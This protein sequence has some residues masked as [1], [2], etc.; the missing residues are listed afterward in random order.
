[1]STSKAGVPRDSQNNAVSQRTMGSRISESRSSQDDLAPVFHEAY[2]EAQV[3]DARRLVAAAQQKWFVTKIHLDRMSKIYPRSL[4][5][6]LE[7]EGL[8]L[9]HNAQGRMLK[10]AYDHAVDDHRQE[11]EKLFKDSNGA[12]ASFPASEILP[13][14]WKGIPLFDVR[15]PAQDGQEKRVDFLVLQVNKIGEPVPVQIGNFRF[16]LKRMDNPVPA[17]CEALL[18]AAKTV[19]QEYGECPRVASIMYITPWG[20]NKIDFAV[21]ALPQSVSGKLLKDNALSPVGTLEEGQT[22][23]GEALP[24]TIPEPVEHEKIPAI[25][26]GEV[27]AA[28]AS[29]PAPIGDTPTTGTRDEISTTLLKGDAP[30]EDPE[31]PEDE[32]IGVVVQTMAKPLQQGRG[33]VPKNSIRIEGWIY[34]KYCDRA[35][36]LQY[37]IA[38]HERYIP[39]DPTSAPAHHQRRVIIQLNDIKD[40][41]QNVAH[42][43]EDKKIDRHY[44]QCWFEMVR[45]IEPD[46]NG[47]TVPSPV[48]GTGLD[49]YK[50]RFPHVDEYYNLLGLPTRGLPLGF[51]WTPR[52]FIG[53]RVPIYFPIAVPDQEQ[54]FY[55]PTFYV[56]RP[57]SGKTNALKA[58]AAAALGSVSFANGQ[59]PAFVFFDL[60]GQFAALKKLPPDAEPESDTSMDWES[61]NLHSIDPARVTV[62][63]RRD[64][65]QPVSFAF[66][67]LLS[68]PVPDQ[69][70][71]LKLFLRGMP[72]ATEHVFDAI[73]RQILSGA[74]GAPSSTYR[75]FQRLFEQELAM[76]RLP[77][78]RTLNVAQRNALHAAIRGAETFFDQP[79]QTFSIRTLL[80]PGRAVVFDLRDLPRECAI[81]YVLASLQR[82]KFAE[83]FQTPVVV[84]IDEAHEVFRKATGAASDTRYLNLIARYL[85]E[86]AS[87][88]RKYRLGLWLASQKPQDLHRDVNGVIVNHYIFGL[89]PEHR[90]WLTTAIG[91]TWAVEAALQLEAGFAFF[92]SAQFHKGVPILLR[93]PRSPNTHGTFV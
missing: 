52:G 54:V 88:G 44:T 23:E 62:L 8:S 21:K 31:D 66:S 26:C 30:L 3:E 40:W 89:N 14:L 57:G 29:T 37:F 12:D 53:Y 79:G 63:S 51:Y 77:I 17:D 71:V 56:G 76:P 83:S 55:T 25:Q 90:T 67:E 69:V 38:Q 48:H 36:D 41:S 49:R 80:Q 22:V 72:A 43:M 32:W 74:A 46:T 11:V 47:S 91:R 45:F 9:Q 27:A 87:R 18:A 13:R 6:K 93:I 86:F 65:A 59:P 58:H 92:R 10:Q 1:M 16:A 82:L 20:I 61:L 24:T 85:A 84:V 81:L 60:E 5:K 15:F 34:P 70:Q 28:N 33:R 73:A 4:H 19:E 50:I 64:P 2:L 75:Y 35:L 68:G 39:G 42:E 7:V 78:T